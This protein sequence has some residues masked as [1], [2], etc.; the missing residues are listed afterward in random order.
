MD[1]LIMELTELL[2][3]MDRVYKVI[4]RIVNSLEA[5][6]ISETKEAFEDLK[7][8]T[9]KTSYGFV[10]QINSYIEASFRGFWENGEE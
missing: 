10:R 3:D 5:D 1:Y 7:S 6:S 2:C 8:I 4:R 9:N